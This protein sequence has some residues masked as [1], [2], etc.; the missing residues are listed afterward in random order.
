MGPGELDGAADAAVDTAYDQQPHS[1]TSLERLIVMPSGDSHTA[2]AGGQLR[3]SFSSSCG[4]AGGAASSQSGSMAVRSEPGPGNGASGPLTWLFRRPL[5]RTSSCSSGCQVHAG[6]LSISSD[7]HPELASCR[8]AAA[9]AASHTQQGE[10]QQQ[11]QLSDVEAGWRDVGGS[12]LPALSGRQQSG[13]SFGS[14]IS[15]IFGDGSRVES[16]STRRSNTTD[17]LSANNRHQ[18]KSSSLLHRLTHRSSR[19]SSLVG[20][21]GSTGLQ[22]QPQ[23]KALRISVRIGIAS[24]TL[25]YGSDLQNCDVTQTAKGGFD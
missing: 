5:S 20:P 24:G 6:Q 1:N 12:K 7:T 21:L 13:A 2:L 3:L 19:N 22:Q 8:T 16:G 11:Q 14:A 4:K 17:P 25:Q 18:S 15:Y 10:L 9:A 23:V